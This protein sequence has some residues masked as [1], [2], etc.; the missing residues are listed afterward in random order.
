MIL[1]VGDAIKLGHIVEALEQRLSEDV[2][3]VPE[4][5]DIR[6][7]END[8]L[9]AAQGARAIIYDTRQYYND[10]DELC[11][12]I[13][14][15]WRANHIDAILLV[16]TGNPNNEIVKAALQRQLKHIVNTSVSYGE[17]K[18]QLEQIFTGYLDANGREDIREAEQAVE[19]QT[20]TL[21]AFVGELYD[22]K[23]REDKA[24][25]TVIVRKKG[26]VQVLLDFLVGF[27]KT[28]ATVV[29]IILMA[30]AVF[31]LVYDNTREPLLHNLTEIWRQVA[32]N[33]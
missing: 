23:Q 29:S 1:C 12:S 33:F 26:T 22:A 8:V 16:P 9:L 19:E 6:R 31:A 30:I 13:K 25:R 5:H 10:A 4:Q 21:N 2:T 7:Q 28:L 32:G 11:E 3:F 15:I 27:V 14:R 24:A 17:Q 18:A 20:K